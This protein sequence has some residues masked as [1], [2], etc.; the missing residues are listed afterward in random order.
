[1]FLWW[2]Y[3]VA[4][5]E[6]NRV[7][8]LCSQGFIR[9][10]NFPLA[11]FPNKNLQ[12]QVDGNTGI[13]SIR[14]V[15]ALGLPKISN[16]VGSMLIPT[17][18][19]SPL[20]ST[21]A[22]RVIPLNCKIFL[23]LSTVCSTE[24]LLS[25]LIIPLFVVDAMFGTSSL[26]LKYLFTEHCD[27]SV[28]ILRFPIIMCSFSHDPSQIWT[29][30]NSYLSASIRL[31]FHGHPIVTPPSIRMC[32]TWRFQLDKRCRAPLRI[33]MKMKVTLPAEQ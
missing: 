9:N 29:S 25:L 18:S 10:P 4:P 31:W 19:A 28:I 21:S 24:W 8:P 13:V 7:A 6:A 11:I 20:W 26:I 1:M 22:N 3:F 30:G 5:P 15:H 16:L 33:G 14:D 2:Q 12:R 17:F 32:Y 27:H 23:S